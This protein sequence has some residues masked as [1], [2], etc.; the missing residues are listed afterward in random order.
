MTSPA[1]GR[2]LIETVARCMGPLSEE[3]A[4]LGGMSAL[5]VAQ[6]MFVSDATGGRTRIAALSKIKRVKEK[7]RQ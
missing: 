7:T 4:F 2:V 1:A 5:A 3:V 6:R